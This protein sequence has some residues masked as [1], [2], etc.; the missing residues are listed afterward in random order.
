M[1]DFNEQGFLSGITEDYSNF[2]WFKGEDNN[3]YLNDSERPLAARFWEYEREFFMNYLDKA[4][5][6]MSLANAY[7]QWKAELLNEHLPGNSPNPY[8]DKTDWN[9]VFETG[10]HN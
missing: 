6:S 9:K 2:R 8:G 1:S 10:I 7:E 5:I 4:D 3:P